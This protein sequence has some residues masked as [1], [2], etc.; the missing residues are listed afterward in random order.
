MRVDREPYMDVK[1]ARRI[2]IYIVVVVNVLGDA[3]FV[4]LKRVYA[5]LVGDLI[6]KQMIHLLSI[7]SS[8]GF[9]FFS[10][11][12]NVKADLL[13]STNLI[14]KAGVVHELLQLLQLIQVCDPALTDFLKTMK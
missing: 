12:R 8:R 3:H 4:L 13:Y 2:H 5:C 6:K 7:L 11:K 1:Y 9:P 14:Q 10:R